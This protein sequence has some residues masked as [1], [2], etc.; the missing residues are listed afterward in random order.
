VRRALL[1]LLFIFFYKLG[2]SMATALGHAVLSGHGL[3]Q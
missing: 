2:D 3:F 1:V